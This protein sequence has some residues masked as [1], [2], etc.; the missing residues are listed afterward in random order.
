M[1]A[2]EGSEEKHTQAISEAAPER[3]PLQNK[4]ALWY[5]KSD[6]N[7][8][9]KDNL[10]LVISFDTVSIPYHDHYAVYFWHEA[11]LTDLLVSASEPSP[12]FVFSI[13]IVYV[14]ASR[15]FCRAGATQ[16]G[17]G[18]HKTCVVSLV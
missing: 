14:Y 9:W 1:A 10:K 18:R 12:P 4:W 7:K 8:E 16:L 15:H 3:H 11:C 17:Q 13:I 6:K 5:F 2:V